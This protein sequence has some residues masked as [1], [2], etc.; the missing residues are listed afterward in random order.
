MLMRPMAWL[1]VKKLV[2]LTVLSSFVAKFARLGVLHVALLP[3]DP[4]MYKCDFDD[5]VVQIDGQTCLIWMGR[6][7]QRLYLNDIGSSWDHILS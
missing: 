7:T 6:R 4:C 5:H 1:I 2:K 3:P